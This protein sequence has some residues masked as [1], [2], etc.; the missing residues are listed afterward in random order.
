MVVRLLPLPPPPIT[1]LA[2]LLQLE[3]ALRDDAVD[4]AEE[5]EEREEREEAQWVLQG[6]RDGWKQMRRKS[7]DDVAAE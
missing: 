1:R 6:R 2:P 3:A 4:E 5:V 7:S